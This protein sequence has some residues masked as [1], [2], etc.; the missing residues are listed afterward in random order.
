MKALIKKMVAI[1]STLKAPKGQFNS[2]GKYKYRSCEDIVEAVK[3]LLAKHELYMSMI[4]KII[5]HSE[6]RCY[7][8]ASIT[9]TDGENSIHSHAS[10]RESLTKKGMDLPGNFRQIQILY[11]YWRFN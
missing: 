2:F 4:D 6:N 9:V 5:Y 10:A 7:V 8:E 1:Q 3:P 11:R